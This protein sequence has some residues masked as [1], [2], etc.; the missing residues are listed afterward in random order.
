MKPKRPDEESIVHDVVFEMELVKQ[1]EVNIDYIL[2]LVVKYHESNCKDEEILVSI[3]K[4]IKSSLELRSKKDLIQ[5]FI[6]RVNA[7]T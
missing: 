4:A 6:D 1:V 2:M 3:D 5:R 7:D